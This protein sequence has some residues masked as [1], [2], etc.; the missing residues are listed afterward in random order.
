MYKLYRH[1]WSYLKFIFA[2][3]LYFSSSFR[4]LE[5][6]FFH[7]IVNFLAILFIKTKATNATE[8]L[9]HLCRKMQTTE[10]L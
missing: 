6:E 10:T 8:E 5:T 2:S 1:A 3:M 9:L 7:Y 4:L